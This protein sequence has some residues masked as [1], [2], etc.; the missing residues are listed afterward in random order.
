[1]SYLFNIFIV[2]LVMCTGKVGDDENKVESE[3]GRSPSSRQ[4][5]KI[6]LLIT[7]AKRFIET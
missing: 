3:D 6:R 7:R 5:G 2:F 1:M 4:L